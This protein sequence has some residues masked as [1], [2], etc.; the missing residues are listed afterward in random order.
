MTRE[1]AE[2][3]GLNDLHLAV[4]NED[5]QQVKDLLRTREELAEEVTNDGYSVW[6][7]GACQNSF[8]VFLALSASSVAT[9]VINREDSRGYTALHLLASQGKIDMLE[10]CLFLLDVKAKTKLGMS[11]LHLA[12]GNPKM[13]SLLIGAGVENE[14]DSSGRLALHVASSLGASYLESAAIL[15][16]A[17]PKDM[18]EKSQEGATA[19]MLAAKHNHPEMVSLLLGLGC[20]PSCHGGF[21]ATALH[22]AVEQGSVECVRLLCSHDPALVL[23]RDDDGMTVRK[24]EK[25]K[26]KSFLCS[27][28][29]LAKCLHYLAGNSKLGRPMLGEMIK[30][31]TDCNAEL[32]DQT[33]YSGATALVREFCCVLQYGWAEFFNRSRR[34]FT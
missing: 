10:H 32:I 13:L 34:R 20:D 19:L 5:L 8:N 25:R 17:F 15:C 12:I 16:R 22:R 7:L 14:A 30:L 18:D 24:K 21:G 6:H 1:E 29:V 11:A 28:F 33:D 2:A 3:F 27:K 31:L 9:K 23:L 26:N 4:R